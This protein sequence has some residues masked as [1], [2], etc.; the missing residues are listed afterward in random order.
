[1]PSPQAHPF[2]LTSPQAEG[3]VGVVLCAGFGTRLR[4]LTEH[5]AKPALPFLG[6]P[7]AHYAFANLARAGIS[8]VGANYHHLPHTMDAALQPLAPALTLT[9]HT[10]EGE[11]LGTGGGL[12]ELWRRLGPDKTVVLCHGDVLLGA[13]L[14]PIVAAHLASGVDVTLV[15][16]VREPGMDLRG[17][18]TDQ[19]GAVVQI[20]KHQGPR[21]APPLMEHAFSG[22]HILSPRVLE[23]IAT[24]G[25]DCLVT[26][27]YPALLAQGAAIGA[28]LTTAFFA[29]L[30]T[31][32]R[33][34]SAQATVLA[35]PWCLPGVDSATGVAGAA[36][37]AGEITGMAG[38]HMDGPVHV[39]GHLHLDEDV[40][41]GPNVALSGH[42]HLQR[43][44]HLDHCA[45][46]GQGTL[47][48][49]HQNALIYLSG[50][51]AIIAPA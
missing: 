10:E 3:V 18:F 11:I 40:V 9:S 25:P 46:W 8:T 26:R 36:L 23:H 29:D 51:Q 27:V 39:A 31:P 49:T 34:L 37:G 1:M 22:V 15:L 21:L 6:R 38:A 30:G 20:L 12:R 13:E 50:E 45:V 5:F 43:G 7:L 32:A 35:M 24:A 16:K 4:P 42:I 14:R 48:G 47:R 2:A 28:Y 44:C 19:S 17:V 33:Y 41:I